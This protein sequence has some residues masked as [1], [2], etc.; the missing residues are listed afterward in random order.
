MLDFFYTRQKKE[1][2]LMGAVEGG[3]EKMGVGD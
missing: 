1:K 3:G 2:N